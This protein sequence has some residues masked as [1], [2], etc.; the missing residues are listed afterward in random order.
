M[1]EDEKQIS[2]LNRYFVFRKTTHIN[3]E[4]IAKWLKSHPMMGEP[5]P[6]EIAEETEGI[7]GIVKLDMKAREQQ[8]QQKLPTKK[9]LKVVEALVRT[10]E[11]DKKPDQPQPFIRKLDHPKIVIQEYEPVEEAPTP[12]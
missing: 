7:E 4:K 3:T 8:Q 5:V 6:P 10:P 12:K 11:V 1:S 9:K 2:F